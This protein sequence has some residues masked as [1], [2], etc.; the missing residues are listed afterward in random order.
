[1]M[2][3][4]QKLTGKPSIDRPWMQYYPQEMIENLTVPN[5]TIYEYLMY[6][7]PG[8]DVVAIHYYGR[9]ITW[10]QIKEETDKV[11]RALKAVGFGENDEIPMFLRSVPEFIFLLLGAEKIGA[12]LLCRDNTI[13]E[14]VA[15][16][17][18]AGA[19]IIFAHD[20]LSQE[21]FNK[22]R[23]CGVREA[24]LLSPLRSADKS[25]LPDYSRDFLNSQYTDYPA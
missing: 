3:I 11:A 10:K 19:K 23:A 16:V 4:K 6:N 7:C 2:S 8:D 5:S 9:D 17:K 12:S 18:K 24:I 21:D 14:N 13:E 1:M 20:F 22:F 25:T 15:A